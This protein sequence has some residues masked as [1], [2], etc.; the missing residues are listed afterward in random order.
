MAARRRQGGFQLRG[1]A[2]AL[3]SVGGA[4]IPSSG[5]ELPTKR[6]CLA[7]FPCSNFILVGCMFTLSQCLALCWFYHAGCVIKFHTY[8]APAQRH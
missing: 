5:T 8:R 7:S 1:F 2:T 3:L 4:F 6:I